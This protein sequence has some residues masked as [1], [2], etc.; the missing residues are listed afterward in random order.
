MEPGGARGLT[1]QDPS[2]SSLVLDPA[3]LAE[4][5]YHFIQITLMQEA[6]IRGDLE[7]VRSPARELSALPM[8]WRVPASASP[9]VNLIRDAARRLVAASTQAEAADNASTM[10]GVCGDCHATVGVHPVP[11]PLARR[12]VGGMVGHMLEHQL[13]MDE[14]VQ[15]LIIPSAILWDRGSRRLQTAPLSRSELSPAP[16]VTSAIHKAEARVHELAAEAVQAS[17]S[18]RRAATYGRLLATCAQCHG[19]HSKIW[20]P[21]TDE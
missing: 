6:V 20:G 3:R 5:Q 17:T 8:P 11:S 4:M 14:L 16:G 15:G 9:H 13:A 21:R 2:T 18:P 7:A 19:L 1:A 10:L 12:E